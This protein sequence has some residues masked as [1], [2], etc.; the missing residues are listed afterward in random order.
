M[1]GQLGQPMYVPSFFALVF[2]VTN[3]VGM[4]FRRVYWFNLSTGF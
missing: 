4:S 1:F 2:L 3:I